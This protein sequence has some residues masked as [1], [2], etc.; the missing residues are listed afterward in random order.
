M[1]WLEKKIKINGWKVTE[2]ILERKVCKREN[3]GIDC[4]KKK[5]KGDRKY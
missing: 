5:L 3:L 4:K 1:P 2:K